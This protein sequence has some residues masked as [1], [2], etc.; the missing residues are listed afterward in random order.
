MN[1]KNQ[2][3]S[4]INNSRLLF[5]LCFLAC[6]GVLLTAVFLQYVVG[7]APCALCIVQRVFFGLVGI[8]CLIAVIHDPKKVGTIIYLVFAVLFAGAGS[9]A[10]IRQIYIQDLPLDQMPACL[11]S[12]D[13]MIDVLPFDEVI[14]LFIYGTAECAKLDWTLF[15]IGIPEWS[16][17]TFAGLT[18]A[19]GLILI[20]A[21]KS[22]KSN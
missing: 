5:L 6:A 18:V 11:P 19:L 13:Y 8:T 22:S 14:K 20:N 7:L 17:I 12:L 4:W 3:I 2:F 16:L 9:A 1:L 21:L 10:A 15:G